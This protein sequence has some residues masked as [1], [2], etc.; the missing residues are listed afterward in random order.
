MTLYISEIVSNA[1]NKSLIIADCGVKFCLYNTEIQD[2]G[3]REGGTVDDVTLNTVNEILC[4]RALKYCIKLLEGKDYSI[5]CIKNKLKIKYYTDEAIEFAVNRLIDK[6]YLND[7]N[8][9]ENYYELK[10]RNF[11]IRRIK[12]ELIKNGISD[13]IID[14]VLSKEEYS[15]DDIELINRLAVSKGFDLEASNLKEKDRFYKFLVRKGID[16]DSINRYFSY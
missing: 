10:K 14:D 11:G 16:F 12:N 9:A 8:F 13:K 4:Q 5:F 1:R 2:F 15:Q 3:I 6:G 7:E